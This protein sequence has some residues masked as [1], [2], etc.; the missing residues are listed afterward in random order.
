MKT[1]SKKALLQKLLLGTERNKR[2]WPGIAILFVGITLLS[3]AVMIWAS[4]N[5]LLEG[6]EALGGT[7]LTINKSIPDEKIVEQKLNVFTPIEIQVIKAHPQVTDVGI[8]NTAAFPV[9]V[10]FKGDTV[11]YTSDIFIEAVP[12][13]FIDK[14]PLGWAWHPG[15]KDVP[16]IISKEFLNL[17]NFGFAPNESVPQLTEGT[18]ITLNFELTIGGA[19]Y[20]ETYNTRVVGFSNRISSIIAP[21]DFIEYANKFFTSHEVTPPT[22]LILKVKD[23]SDA[24]FTAFLDERNYH[25]NSD[26][27]RLSKIRLILQQA[28]IGVSIVVAFAFVF[29]VLLFIVFAQLMLSKTNDAARLLYLIGYHPVFLHRYLLLRY[30]LIVSLTAA[31]SFVLSVVLQIRLAK[32]LL[33]YDL[34]IRKFP[35]EEVWI[36]IV[37]VSFILLVYINSV[38]SSKIYGK[39]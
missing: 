13:R 39:K 9:S 26:L 8:Y 38:I 11:S 15:N 24:S 3:F 2:L 34:I 35:A 12:D 7:F 23:P 25:T 36:S 22:R 4:F 19:R 14:L 5:D 32:Y 31:L 1:K 33:G 28:S 10:T 17:Y 27:D 21:S 18:I 16:V 20:K 6:K 37:G 30:I 29:A